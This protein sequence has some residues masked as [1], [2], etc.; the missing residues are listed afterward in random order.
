MKVRG[1][2]ARWQQEIAA[3]GVDPERA[4]ALDARFAAAYATVV[5]RRRDAFAGTDLDPEAN[6]RRLE[7][8]VKRVED[9]AASLGGQSGADDRALSPTTRL[10][11]M[12]KEAL[13]ANTIG[14]KVDEG[15]RSR[16]AIEEVR[17]AQAN[18]SRVG[19]VPEEARAPLASRF[20]RACRRITERAAR[21][22]DRAGR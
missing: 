10:A 20:Q 6:R 13:A 5:E 4:R 15:N 16:A 22:T 9:L 14:G 1:L 17:Q 2:R 12:L 3:R 11:A 8:L 18:W 7:S 21:A 19:P